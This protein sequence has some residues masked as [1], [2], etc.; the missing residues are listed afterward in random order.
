MKPSY[1]PGSIIANIH[2]GGSS[3][4]CSFD[5]RLVYHICPFTFKRTP[6][7]TC[8]QVPFMEF[9]TTVKANQR[10]IKTIDRGYMTFSEIT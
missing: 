4:L 9:L 7:V 1:D 6:I 2:I 5:F 8:F 3:S 10:F